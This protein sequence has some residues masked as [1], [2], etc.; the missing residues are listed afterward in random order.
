[1]ILTELLRHLYWVRR[2]GSGYV[3]RC[4]AHE[5]KRPSLSLTEDTGRI[6]LCCHAGCT[7]EQI[8]KELGLRFSDLFDQRIDRPSRKALGEL[9]IPTGRDHINGVTIFQGSNA[10]KVHKVY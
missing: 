10:K 1:M 2:C 8:L 7:T 9:A 3:A 4:P 5:D 6:L